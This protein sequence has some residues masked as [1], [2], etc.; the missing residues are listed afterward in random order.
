MVRQDKIPQTLDEYIERNHAGDY[1]WT[2]M[3]DDARQALAAYEITDGGNLQD[4]I[5]DAET[6]ADR[7]M[8]RFTA[9]G[10]AISPRLLAAAVENRAGQALAQDDE[11]APDEA[12]TEYLTGV[13]GRA[14]VLQDKEV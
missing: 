11:K 9:E 12:L 7:D 10:F 4:A 2:I 13:L 8:I 5:G 3:Q 14:R 6:F 1:N